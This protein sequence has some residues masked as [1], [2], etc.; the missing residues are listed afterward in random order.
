MPSLP[1]GWN[2][3][4]RYRWQNA[5]NFYLPRPLGGPFG[6]RLGELLIELALAVGEVLGDDDADFRQQIAL[7]TA[8]LREPPP[9][10]PDLAAG[11][12]ARRD[13]YPYRPGRGL[14]VRLAAQRGLRGGDWDG[15]ED[16]R[17]LDPVARI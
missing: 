1:S 7:A 2:F 4:E 10:Q 14:D 16:V 17:S 5:S 9:P 3:V 13:A 8:G 6:L 12:G 15:G 11:G